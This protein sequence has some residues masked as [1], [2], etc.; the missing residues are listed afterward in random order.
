MKHWAKRVLQNGVYL[1]F[2]DIFLI[3]SLHGIRLLLFSY[4]Q[5]RLGMVVT[6]IY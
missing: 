6:Q 5:G 1:E 4:A 3:C 2:V